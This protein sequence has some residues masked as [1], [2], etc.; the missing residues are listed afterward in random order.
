METRIFKRFSKHNKWNDY[1]N[2]KSFECKMALITMIVTLIKF[3]VLNIYSNFNTYLLSLQNMTIYT[4]QALMGMLGIILAG[5]AI[6]VGVL[7]KESIKSIEKHNGKGSIQGALISFE[8]LAFN[9]GIGIFAFL[10]LNLV[11]Y[12]DKDLISFSFFYFIVAMVS[13]FLAFIIFY[14]ISLIGN[15]I[16]VFYINDIY[17]DISAKE[18]STYEEANEVRIDYLLSTLQKQMNLS[19]EEILEDLDKLVDSINSP[20]KEAVKKYLKD[21]YSEP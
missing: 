8:F 7:N 15:C 2:F 12:S 17:S 4:F 11:L 9:I 1:Y 3:K 20:N 18:R 16:R 10:L 6:I 21:Y 19:P 5:L 13:Y 14:T